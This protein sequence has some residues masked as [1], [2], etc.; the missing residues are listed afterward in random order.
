MLDAARAEG[1]LEFVGVLDPRLKRG[2]VFEALTCLGDDAELATLRARGID[3][4]VLGV[5][6]IDVT[7][8]RRTL[9]ERA[10][11]SGLIMPVIRHPRATI[12]TTVSIGDATVVLAGAI[13]N[14]GTRIGRNVI[15]NTGALVDHDCIV[16]DH[17]H[18]SPGAHIGG[19]VRIGDH[20]H[21]G[22]GSTIIQGVEVGSRVLVG[23]GAVVVQDVA[24]GS[25][26][27]GVPARPL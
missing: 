24:S 9:Y 16:S 12:S 11:D 13:I 10:V 15:V 26:V 21:I 14:P 6:S 4:A 8:R 7:E 22:I 2:S 18:I 17:V 27:A 20:S 19:G 23:A 1:T 3:G 5:G 25:R